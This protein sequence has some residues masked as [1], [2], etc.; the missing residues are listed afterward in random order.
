MLTD[1]LTLGEAGVRPYADWQKTTTLYYPITDENPGA[2]LLSRAEQRA[3]LLARNYTDIVFYADGRGAPGHF[4]EFSLWSDPVTFRARAQECVDDGLGVHVFLC[5]KGLFEETSEHTPPTIAEVKAAWSTFVPAVD[6]LVTSWCVCLEGNRS[7]T[8]AQHN[9]LGAHLRT[10]TAK[11]IAGHFLPADWPVMGSWMTDIWYQHKAGSGS[12]LSW[13]LWAYPGKLNTAVNRGLTFTAFEYNHKSS[14]IVSMLIGKVLRE[15]GVTSFANGIS[16]VEWAPVG[17]AIGAGDPASVDLAAIL[18]AIASDDTLRTAL[19]DVICP[20]LTP[21]DLVAILDATAS[22]G[23]LLAALEGAICSQPD[24]GPDPD[25]K[26]ITGFMP[27]GFTVPAGETWEIVGIV[28]TDANVIVAGTLRMRGSGDMD[29][30][31][32]LRFINVDEEAFVGGGLDPVATDVG[33]WGVGD[34]LL[35]FI[36]TKRTRWCRG[37]LPDDWEDTDD[38]LIVPHLQDDYG[39]DG[40]D[41]YLLGD[42]IPTIILGDGS[43]THTEII[44]LSCDVQVCGTP[45]GRSH[46]TIV[47]DV[48]QTTKWF[49]ARWMGPRKATGDSNIS[50]KVGGRVGVHFHRMGEASRGSLLEG[51]LVMDCGSHGFQPHASSGITLKDTL[52]YRSNETAYWWNHSL[53]SGFGNDI[54]DEDE[55]RAAENAFRTTADPVFDHCGSAIITTIPVFRGAPSGFLLGRVEGTAVVRDCFAAG[56]QSRNSGAGF[57][58]PSRAN[59]GKVPWV[60]EDCVSHNNRCNGLRTWQNTVTGP[61]DVDV[62]V[63]H[64]E[65]AAYVI[66]AYGLPNYVF[67]VRATRCGTGIVIWAQSSGDV[68][69]SVIHFN[70][71]NYA[72]R[73]TGKDGARGYMAGCGRN[74]LWKKHT[75]APRRPV[76][77]RDIDFTPGAL[78]VLQEIEG[79]AGWADFVECTQVDQGQFRLDSLSGPRLVDMKKE[80]DL[81]I[82][83][84]TIRISSEEGSNAARM[85]GGVWA[86]V[87]PFYPIPE[88]DAAGFQAPGEI[89]EVT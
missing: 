32:T 62:L 53:P 83:G 64:C 42:D 26:V 21:V 71:A 59:G 3:T 9:E 20:E 57:Q 50:A 70:E 15:L 25:V 88:P 40:L 16:E 46:I 74:M 54:V 43:E 60:V 17:E 13:I 1:F 10:L 5:Q 7:L 4:P 28:E 22:D 18:D 37:V 36:G 82:P 67:R 39:L 72:L 77:L 51:V 38:M 89:V 33:L 78:F 75:A 63:Y 2:F 49:C 14:E 65:K 27:G 84:T 23:A 48:P 30:P 86:P 80:T 73:F 58:W 66:G 35:D 69:R 52:V 29:D 8:D 87:D 85:A 61:H 6:D 12:R 34:G 47:G 81:T 79:K 55:R 68:R 45:G 41:P 19:E 76:L 31:T 24:P 11:P 56:N 44:N